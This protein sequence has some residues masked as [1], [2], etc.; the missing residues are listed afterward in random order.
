VL[1]DA[2]GVVF[3]EIGTGLNGVNVVIGANNDVGVGGGG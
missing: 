3:D 2:V 1:V